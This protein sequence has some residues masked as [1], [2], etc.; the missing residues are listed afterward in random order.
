M[1]AAYGPSFTTS[2]AGPVDVL[3]P[4][5]PFG[6]AFCVGVACIVGFVYLYSTLPN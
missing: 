6:V 5:D 2:V 3:K 1:E 4:N